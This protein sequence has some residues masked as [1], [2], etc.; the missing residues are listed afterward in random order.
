MGNKKWV[1]NP[2]IYQLGE[3]NKPSYLP[4]E[5]A[6][7]GEDFRQRGLGVKV[8]LKYFLS[9]YHTPFSFE[10]K[11]G[12]EGLKNHK[13]IYLILTFNTLITGIRF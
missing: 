1:P 7:K 4:P 3:W 6:Y 12:E 13:A 5:Y 10:G 8:I 2:S 11:A 9:L